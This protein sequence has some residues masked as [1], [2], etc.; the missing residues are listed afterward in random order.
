MVTPMTGA[1]SPTVSE[2]RAPWIRRESSSRPS[3]SVPSQ[4][5]AAGQRAAGEHV[6]VGRARDRQDVGQRRRERDQDDPSD[7]DQQ[8]H[9]GLAAAAHR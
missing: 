7:G 8:Q 6:H 9:A 3:W 2:M 4:C 1:S 5:S